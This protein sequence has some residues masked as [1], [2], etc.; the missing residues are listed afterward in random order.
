MWRRLNPNVTLKLHRKA[1][2][3]SGRVSQEQE[4]AAGT[5]KVQLEP[6]GDVELSAPGGVY[7]LGN[8]SCTASP[9][10]KEM[11]RK[12]LPALSG[13]IVSSGLPRKFGVFLKPQLGGHKA[14]SETHLSWQDS[15]QKLPFAQKSWPQKGNIQVKMFKWCQTVLVGKRAGN[16]DS[17]PPVSC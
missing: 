1:P 11:G 9:S 8:C 15:S 3:S 4:Q 5:G 13:F 6:P 16:A 17:I 12:E 7:N 10:R 14:V 2:K